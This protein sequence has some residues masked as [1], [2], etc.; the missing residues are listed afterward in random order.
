MAKL[1]FYDARGHQ[2]TGVL[3][4]GPRDLIA[5]LASIPDTAMVQNMTMAIPLGSTDRAV[6]GA[7]TS[8]DNGGRGNAVRNGGE[9]RAAWFT[10]I[11]TAWGVRVIPRNVPDS[12]GT[13]TRN[14]ELLVML[15]ASL[16]REAKRDPNGYD[17]MGL[18]G[19][20]ILADWVSQGGALHTMFMDVKGV[21]GEPGA[22]V[23]MSAL[24]RRY[25]LN[26]QATER[27]SELAMGE[28]M[29]AVE[30]MDKMRLVPRHITI[31]STG[32]NGRGRCLSEALETMLRRCL[33]SSDGDR[34][35]RIG[36]YQN[37]PVLG[38]PL[39]TMYGKFARAIGW[40]SSNRDNGYNHFLG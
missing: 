19:L 21:M 29:R 3:K 36:N 38:I 10:S 37:D 6:M 15:P 13:F 28:G 11:A 24:G 7:N 23:T 2:K 5:F 4:Q 17:A 16:L 32:E 14:R 39:L 27:I 33:C 20:M 8:M 25:S 18:K 12:M 22:K 30:R 1:A 35:I 9:G 34:D 26:S 40:R 31:P